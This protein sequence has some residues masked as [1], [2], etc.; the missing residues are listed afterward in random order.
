MVS[1][2]S[3]EVLYYTDTLCIWAYA[4]QIRIDELKKQFGECVAVTHRFI[5]VFGSTEDR[6]GKGWENRSGYAGRSQTHLNT[7]TPYTKEMP[8][9]THSGVPKKP[10]HARKSFGSTATIRTWTDLT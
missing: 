5:S 10:S 1:S 6:I 3:V 9:G 8:S 2:G 4:G 7:A